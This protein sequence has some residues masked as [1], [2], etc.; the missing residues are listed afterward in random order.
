MK[1]TT[2]Q[3]VLVRNLDDE[4]WKYALYS[5]SEEDDDVVVVILYCAAGT[6]W[7]QCIPYEGN[8]NLVGTTINAEKKFEL[9]QYVKVWGDARKISIFIG[10]LD[11]M[12][13]QTILTER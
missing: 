10:L 2:G 12:T 3:P 8:E 5:H 4:S 7:E 9:G 6:Y 1:L 11:A 13:I